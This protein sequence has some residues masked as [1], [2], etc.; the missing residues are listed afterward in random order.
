MMRKLLTPLFTCGLSGLMLGALMLY[1]LVS[2]HTLDLANLPG[3]DRAWVPLLA[4]WTSR[5]QLLRLC[6][7]STVLAQ[8]ALWLWL[9]ERSGV[10]AWLLALRF[11]RLEAHEPPALRFGLI[12]FLA[13]SLAGTVVQHLGLGLDSLAIL[14]NLRSILLKLVAGGL[15]GYAALATFRGPSWRLRVARPA[16]ALGAGLGLSLL[17]WQD[18]LEPLVFGQ[19]PLQYGPWAYLAWTCAWLALMGA[20]LGV[21]ATWGN[22]SARKSDLPVIPSSS[23]SSSPA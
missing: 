11:R 20:A 4:L 10:L 8:M 2:S 12:A 6:A 5:L 22:E 1:W 16:A 21:L 15:L 9:L 19:G 3:G 7:F 13:G 14:I 23:N 18:F 17:P